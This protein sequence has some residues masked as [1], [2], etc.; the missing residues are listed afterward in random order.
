MSQ[1][2]TE[3]PVQVV[4]AVYENGVFRPLSP[5][6]LAGLAEHQRVR[7]TVAAVA[8][9]ASK[10]TPPAEVPPEAD[11]E[12]PMADAERPMTVAERARNRIQGD[13]KLAAEIALDDELSLINIRCF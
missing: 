13:P 7:L 4:E 11:A 10:P 6:A 12:R 5:P 8:E 1:T 9:T 2:P 3:D